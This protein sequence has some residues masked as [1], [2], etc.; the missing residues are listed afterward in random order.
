MKKRTAAILAL[1]LAFSLTACGAPAS[2]NEETSAEKEEASANDGKG[3]SITVF[4]YMTQESKQKGLDAVEQAFSEAHPEYDITWDNVFYNQ[5]T[6]YFPQL[7][8]ALAGGEQPEIMMGNPGLYP[9]LVEQGYTADLTD[10]ATINSLDLPSG[11]MGDVS[12]DGKIYGFPIDFKTWGVFYNKAIYEELELEEPA[13]YTELLESCQKIAEAGYD[14]WAHAFGDAVFGDIEMRN[15]VWTK[16]LEAGDDD[17]FENLMN[18]KKKLTDYEYFADG[19]DLWAQR[20]QWMRD[21]AMTNDQNAALEVFTSGKAAML[22]FGT[23]GIGDLEAM[24]EGTDFEYGF[25]VEPIDDD[26]S[27]KLN[28]QVDQS[29]M[30]NPNAD[31]YDI[32]LEFMEFWVT[33]GTSTW[34]AISLCPAL[35]GSASDDMPDAIKTL[36]EIKSSGEISHY[37][38]FTMPFNTQFTTDWRTY[39]TAFAESYAKGQGE[40]SEEC[41]NAMQMKF[42]Q[43]IA[44]AE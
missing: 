40:S 16:A 9:D 3:V 31:N 42:D 25:F 11:D 1:T 44:E 30:L 41:L 2:G 38:D 43:D 18:G 4:H 26:G 22:Y 39:L 8:T 37:G 32:A 5:G 23:W 29:F 14:P 36:T 13:T 7:Q 10:N 34:A 15:Y 21:D 35:K 17:V 28:V 19:L 24:I 20:L 12:S 27:A 33:E 6:D